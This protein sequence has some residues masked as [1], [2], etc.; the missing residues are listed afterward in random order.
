M[1][2]GAFQFAGSG[3]IQNNL[4]ALKRGITLA[5][6][7]NVRFLL[8]Q[9]CALSGYPPLETPSAA[10]LNFEQ[11]QQGVSELAELAHKHQMFIALGSIQ[12]TEQAT[13]QATETRYQNTLLWLTPDGTT[14]EAYSKKA[15][16]G[17]DSDNFIPGQTSGIYQV[18]GVTL[19][20]RICFE[21]RFPEYFRELF[22]ANVQLAAVSF[23]DVS[24]Q[25]F[26]ARYEL[27]KAHLLTRAVEN[28]IYVLSANG[29]APT[30]PHLPV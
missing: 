17:W 25:P 19:G 14:A 6:E 29:I 3:D 22:K 30:R 7:Q 23:C 21:I 8:T 12:T 27:I 5:A 1:K 16:W 26:Q 24:N 18:D 20:L 10:G 13:A 28:G 15:L 2:I 4:A 11:L 9:E